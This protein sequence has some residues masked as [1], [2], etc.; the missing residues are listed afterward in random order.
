M[1]DNSSNPMAF[2]QNMLGQMQKNFMPF[3]NQAAASPQFSKPLDQTGGVTASVQK[4][5]GDFMER[6]LVSMNMPSRA[7]MAGIAEQLQAIE[8]KLNEI[9]ALLQEMQTA[10]QAG[11][12]ADG[13]LNEIK[14]L[15]QQMQTAPQPGA[16]TDGHLNE[17]KE[18]LQQMQRASQA[19]VAGDSQLNE[20]K[21]L[22]Q[23]M[24][25][26]P[27]AGA[28]ADGHLNEIKELLQQMQKAPQSAAL[29][30][31]PSRA[32]RAPSAEAQK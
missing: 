19:G 17:I 11:V 20:I 14:E 31:K 7:Q 1:A 30:P 18:L 24:Q 13:Q 25:I 29:P 8:G 6:Y 16:A 22:L 15:L 4:Q 32:K 3:A 12:A 10:P 2:W 5:F 9:K 23:Q 21:E 28:V 27:Q 26:A